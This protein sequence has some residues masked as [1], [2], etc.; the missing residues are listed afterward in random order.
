MKYMGSKNRIAK[1]IL[2]I[3]LKDRKENQYY[4]E[5]FVGGANM[6]DKVDG[7]RIANDINPYLISLLYNASC[8]KKYIEDISKETYSRARTDYNNKTNN[9]FNDFQLGWIGFMASANGR[10]FEGGYSGTSKTKTGS[11]RNYIRESI[12]NFYK[13]LPKLKGIEFKCRDYRG[14][15]IP[16]NSIIYC[17]IPYKNTKQYY[18]SKDFNYDKFWQWCRDKTIE[19]HQVFISEYNAPIDFK[20][21][22]QQEVKSS[23]SANGIS[24]GS[25]ISTE[26]LFTYSLTNKE[27]YNDETDNQLKEDL[28]D[29]NKIIK[30]GIN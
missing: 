24:G 29:C 16:K 23:L 6:I 13:Q 2:P 19:G 1:Y 8:G 14:L 12:D 26:K 15:K 17:D 25:K 18:L 28:L 4:I 27:D 21:I 20:C 3:I 22:W 5:P 11:I 10:F 7:L 9:Y 30:C